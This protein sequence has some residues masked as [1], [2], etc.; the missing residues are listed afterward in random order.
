MISLMSIYRF[1]LARLHAEAIENKYTIRDILAA[2]ESLPEG[3]NAIT[4]TYDNAMQRIKDQSAPDR[5]L[6]EKIIMWISH[7]REPLTLHELQCALTIREGDTA[8]DLDDLIPGELLISACAGLVKVE[9]ET[10]RLQFVHSTVQEYIL[11]TESLQFPDCD[12]QM[13]HVCIQFLSLDMFRISHD[14]LTAPQFRNIVA[15]FPFL[16][17][18]ACE[19]GFHAR[20]SAAH[21]SRAS[22]QAAILGFVDLNTQFVFALRIA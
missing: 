20:L 7:I 6:A 18:A 1:L 10:N 3:R 17:Y 9:K 2:L 15:T 4:E 21:E 14:G 5:E 16:R 13:A 8:L 12:A 22:L 11:A 19:W